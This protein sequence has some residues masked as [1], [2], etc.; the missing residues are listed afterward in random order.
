MRIAVISDIHGNM[1]ALQ[2]VLSDIDRSDIETTICLGD[3]IGYGPQPDEVVHAIRRL[4]IPCLLGNHELAVI[5]NK[6]LSWF[7]ADAQK[8]L[9]RTIELLSDDSRRF[10]KGLYPSHIDFGCRFVHGFPPDSAFLYLF[11]ASE[12]KLRRTFAQ[13]QERICFVGHTHDLSIIEFDGHIVTA[14]LLSRGITRLNEQS[15]YII[16]IGSVGQ[17]RDG[18]NRA[19]YLI[20]D[21]S[22]NT[23]DV[24]Y[25]PYDIARV[26]DKIIAAGFPEIHASRLW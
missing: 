4:K 17:P 18:N 16:N 7:N 23:I 1:D 11:Q 25:I 15:R 21:T 5:D 13:M 2:A 9:R 10:I 20:L 14:G 8:S 26:V 3:N 6:L 12:G 19:K 22:K 24:R